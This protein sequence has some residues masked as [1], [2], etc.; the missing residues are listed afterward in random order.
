MLRYALA[1]ASSRAL[2]MYARPVVERYRDSA[3]LVGIFD[4]NAT[5]ADF[6]S[7]ECGG[8]PVFRDF[9]RMLRETAP[10]TVVVTTVDRFHHDYIIR[11]LEAGCNVITEKPLTIDAEKVRAILA[12]EARTGR[13][14]SPC[15]DASAGSSRRRGGGRAAIQNRR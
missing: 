12:A 13:R 1:G 3:S 15:G 6:V 4:I 7:R 11:S 8:V 10:D 14:R 2:H 5:R 9:D